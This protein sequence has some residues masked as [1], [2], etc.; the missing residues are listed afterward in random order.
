MRVSEFIP[1]RRWCSRTT[2]TARYPAKTT[3]PEIPSH[4]VPRQV[5]GGDAGRRVPD[6]QGGQVLDHPL[7]GRQVAI[8]APRLPHRLGPVVPAFFLQPGKPDAPAAVD[9]GR[10]RR[11]VKIQA[12]ETHRRAGRDLPSDLHQGQVEAVIHGR[13]AV[14]KPAHPGGL[15]AG[16]GETHQQLAV[17]AHSVGGGEDEIPANHVTRAHRP[18]RAGVVAC[19]VEHLHGP[20]GHP[21]TRHHPAARL[22][23]C[24]RCGE[25]P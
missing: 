18:V 20:L 23:A 13:P 21:Q 22:R 9:V 15:L 1:P 4:G 5:P 2:P 7:T 6:P 8:E 16:P 25:P 3:V 19:V 11:R 24:R 17:S 14:G 12:G 10:S